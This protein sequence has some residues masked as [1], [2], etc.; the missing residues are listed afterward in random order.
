MNQKHLEQA[1]LKIYI[2]L[3]VKYKVFYKNVY[4]ISKVINH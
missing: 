4:F 2:D 1:W 3:K